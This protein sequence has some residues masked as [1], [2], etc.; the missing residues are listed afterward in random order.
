[1]KLTEQKADGQ[2]L[3]PDLTIHHRFPS[4]SDSSHYKIKNHQADALSELLSLAWIDS[5]KRVFKEIMRGRNMDNEQSCMI[6]VN[7]S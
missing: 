7:D 4:V 6:D 3:G 1:M 2:V 5:L